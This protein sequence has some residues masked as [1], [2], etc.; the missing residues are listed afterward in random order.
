MSYAGGT[1]G[2]STIILVTVSLGLVGDS[3]SISGRGKVFAGPT[4]PVTEAELSHVVSGW[5]GL[6][7]L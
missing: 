4:R 6:Q 7:W 2:S 1:G 5:F 3:V